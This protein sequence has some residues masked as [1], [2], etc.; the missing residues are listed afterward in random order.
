MLG[1]VPRLDGVQSGDEE[2]GADRF[3]RTKED[4]KVHKA[5]RELCRRLAL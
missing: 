4:R 3:N 5:M 2:I 1:N